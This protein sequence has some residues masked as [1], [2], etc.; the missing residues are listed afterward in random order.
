MVPNSVQIWAVDACVLSKIRTISTTYL[1]EKY[2]GKNRIWEVKNLA[3]ILIDINL[4]NKE[5][6]G[7]IKTC[8]QKQ[9]Y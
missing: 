7:G 4:N 3:N 2:Y 8:F 6:I 9:T 5:V 1:M